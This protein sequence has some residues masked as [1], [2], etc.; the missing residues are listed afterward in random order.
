MYLHYYVYAYLRTDGTPYYIG[1]GTRK[2]AWDKRHRI[3]MP[4][5]P[6]KIVILEGNLSNVGACA[7]ERRLI[8]WW[9]RKDLGT[10]ILRNLTDGGEGSSNSIRSQEYK[11]KISKANKGRKHTEE[12]LQKMRGRTLTD[13]Q[14]NHL[15]LINLGKKNKPKSDNAKQ[16]ISIANTGAGNGMYG[17]THSIKTK[18]KMSDSH[19]NKVLSE[20]TKR[21]IA[22]G[23]RR[24]LDSLRK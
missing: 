11:D 16:R 12:S 20:E 21:K 4:T 19:K 18:Q 22:E 1:K 15:R 9:G 3:S 2:R 7:L 13:S 8:R 14:K 17:T 10:G 5:D 23:R 24:Y 6:T